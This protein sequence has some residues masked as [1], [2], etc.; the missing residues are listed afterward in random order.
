MTVG[1]AM[2]AA[3]MTDAA[4]PMPDFTITPT[5]TS[6]ARVNAGSG[7]FVSCTQVRRALSRTINA[8]TIR[9]SCQRFSGNRDNEND[10]KR[11]E[12]EAPL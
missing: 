9:S 10:G 8:M 4:M 1:I 6:P 2:P 7:E 5:P 3:R 12:I 11:C